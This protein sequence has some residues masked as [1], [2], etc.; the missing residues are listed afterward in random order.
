MPS[1]DE[2]AAG[3]AASASKELE[4]A[5]DRIKHCLGQLT[6]AQVWNRPGAGQNSIA[7]LLLHLAGNLRQWLIVGLGGGENRRDRPREFADDSG[8][9]KAELLAAL[10]ATV[11]EVSSVLARQT[12]AELLRVRRIQG[13]EVTGVGAIFESVAHFRGHTQEIIFRTRQLLGEK[14]RFAWRPET[15]EE[16]A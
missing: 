1:T 4:E 15:K 3:I 7:N 10:E 13:F 14:Y 6:D 8:R 16:G 11:A 5:L 12:A 2:L 9:P